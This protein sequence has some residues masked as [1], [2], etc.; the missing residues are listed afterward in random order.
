MKL[1]I[2]G[3]CSQVLRAMQKSGLS[4]TIGAENICGTI[5]QALK[6]AKLIVKNQLRETG[7]SISIAS[8]VSPDSF[9]KT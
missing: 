7:N 2:S 8:P 5:Q 6:R 1:I 3:A 4:D 9:S